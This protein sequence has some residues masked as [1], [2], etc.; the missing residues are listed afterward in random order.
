MMLSNGE[1]MMW[2]S[3]Q[4]G[5]VN[6]E[7]VMKNYGRWI[8]DSSTAAGY[9]PVNNWGEHDTFNGLSLLADQAEK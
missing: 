3:Q 5:H 2:V 6:V 9:R 4:M 1:N 7:M 8:P